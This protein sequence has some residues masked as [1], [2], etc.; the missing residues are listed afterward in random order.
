MRIGFNLILIKKLFEN[1]IKKLNKKLMKKKNEKIKV[2]WVRGKRIKK[3]IQDIKD[4]NI[5]TIIFI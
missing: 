1:A 4:L 5:K 3:I 2:K